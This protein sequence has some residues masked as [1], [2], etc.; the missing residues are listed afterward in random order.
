VARTLHTLLFLTLVAV[1]LSIARGV[2]A[3]SASGRSMTAKDFENQVQREITPG[4]SRAGAERLLQ[5]WKL[6]YRFVPKEQFRDNNLTTKI[7]KPPE[8]T[9]GALLAT[10]M[11][12]E[13]NVIFERFVELVIFIADDGTVSKAASKTLT[14]GP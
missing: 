14:A 2:S 13:R 11:P 1:L 6:A 4:L 8:R 9:I 3:E 5:S 12:L 7:T 10:T